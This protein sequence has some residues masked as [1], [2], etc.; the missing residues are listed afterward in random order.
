MVLEVS[1]VDGPGG[2][3]DFF[4]LGAR[5]FRHEDGHAVLFEGFEEVEE[6]G[7]PFRGEAI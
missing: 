7:F 3:G 4:T 1:F 2:I 5:L 6:G